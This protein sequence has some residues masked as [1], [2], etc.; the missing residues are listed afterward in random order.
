MER[1]QSRT[2]GSNGQ[3][4]TAPNPIITVTEHTPVPSP[5]YMRRQVEHNLFYIIFTTFLIFKSLI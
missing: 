5:D 2:N 1:K 4:C 3:T